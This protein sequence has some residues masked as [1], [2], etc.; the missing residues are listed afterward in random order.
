MVIPKE[1]IVA[2]V[3]RT[4]VKE[5]ESGVDLWHQR[6]GHIFKEGKFGSG[7]SLTD[8]AE[9]IDCTTCVESKQHKAPSVETLVNLKMDTPFTQ[10]L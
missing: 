7:V 9:T 8:E 5:T 1:S 6:L 3:G 4:K 2:V 10:I